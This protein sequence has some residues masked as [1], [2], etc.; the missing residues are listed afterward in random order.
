M[1]ASNKTQHAA[2]ALYDQV[3][4]H[5]RTNGAV[6]SSEL[7][8]AERRAF[9]KI[10]RD[11]GHTGD[12]VVDALTDA[13]INQSQA[14]S[15]AAEMRKRE[16]AGVTALALAL[17]NPAGPN[18]V[19]PKMSE[20]R[21]RKNMARFTKIKHRDNLSRGDWDKRRKQVVQIDLPQLENE[22]GVAEWLQDPANKPF[23]HAL[24]LP[25]SQ[26]VAIS[27]RY[28]NTGKKN[29][30]VIVVNKKT[31]K[32]TK[33]VRNAAA[34][35]LAN[36]QDTFENPRTGKVEKLHLALVPY[37]GP[38]KDRKGRAGGSA[39]VHV[40]PRTQQ[41]LTAAIDDIKSSVDNA[42]AQSAMQLYQI[43]KADL[44]ALKAR[45]ASEAEI[46]AKMEAVQLAENTLSKAAATAM[47]RV[48]A[49][50]K[51]SALRTVSAKSAVKAA[52]AGGEDASAEDIKRILKRVARIGGREGATPEQ[53]ARGAE[54]Q[55]ILDAGET[56][57]TRMGNVGGKMRTIRVTKPGEVVARIRENAAHHHHHRGN[58]I[59]RRKR[60]NVGGMDAKTI[61]LG[62]VGF[63]GG[64]IVG[65]IATDAVKKLPMVGGYA[66]YLVAAGLAADAWYSHQNRGMIFKNIP[67]IGL[68][69]GLAAGV[70]F[71][72]IARG[73]ASKLLNFARLGMV[74][75]LLG[76]RKSGAAGFGAMDIYDTAFEDVS[77]TGEYL[78]ENGFGEYLA[79]SGFG[80]YASPEM[81]DMA[82]S[83]GL[84][85][86]LAMNG[87]GATV[88]A[89]PAGFGATVTAAPAGFGEYLA[90]S[91]L[92]ATVTAAPAG[93]GEI[94]PAMVREFAGVGSDDDAAGLLDASDLDGLGD[95]FSDAEEDLEGLGD[96]D[97]EDLEGL[98]EDEGL[99]DED[100]AL[101]GL[102]AVAQ[103]RASGAVSS[104]QRVS[105]PMVQRLA[106]SP[107]IRARL[108][109]VRIV[110]RSQRV[111]GTFI[112]AVTR[113]LGKAKLPKPGSIKPRSGSVNISKA[114]SGQATFKP[115]GVFAETVFGGRG[116]RG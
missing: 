91:G 56:G 43:L 100:L 41:L 51:S 108:F 17:P 87:L 53:V 62:V 47:A 40:G 33:S 11:N 111:P 101:E 89:A 99:S 39:R 72:M 2:D 18:A 21:S 12:A 70:I 115:G 57:Q 35:A 15:F 110:G 45:N 82:A 60:H 61:G 46:E 48:A 6:N 104:V 22:P 30:S 8:A 34:I 24:S 80:E 81:D 49:G 52:L 75:N 59:I 55:A 50:K 63:A 67:N 37:V 109:D 113:N 13:G 10:A 7:T 116:F 98:G 84:G 1:A 42:K 78:A 102:G 38:I 29:K 66:P 14:R 96:D 58:G 5:V 26:Q 3:V 93:F 94:N 105:A 103:A 107:S 25:K 97:E 36:N 71:P 83:D 68:R 73:L 28:L 112:V 79:E 9:A 23:G 77:G 65:T 20:I 16:N 76:D 44:D 19:P 90:E 64:T 106:S 85:E 4:G 92:G 69:Y 54:A 27:S 74:D 32:T 114:P 31:G 86:Y 95:D 88:T